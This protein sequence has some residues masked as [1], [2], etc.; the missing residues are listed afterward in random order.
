MK[1]C[2]CCKIPQER[3][4]FSKKTRGSKDG[5]QSRCKT[6]NAVDAEH[7]DR[8]HPG[9]RRANFKTWSKANP[10]KVAKR[11][12]RFLNNRPM[13][14]REYSLLRNYGL[15]QKD[16]DL[17]L[18]KQGGT[19]AICKGESRVIRPGL[20]VDHNHSTGKVRGILCHKCNVALGTLEDSPAR[21]QSVI[22]YLLLHENV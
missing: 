4:C 5:L 17:L 9:H 21:A 12:R 22:E 8:T 3:S 6:C 15:T 2:S 19:C 1:T 11:M 13:Y 14:K 20:C 18:E 16:F 10:E 7:F